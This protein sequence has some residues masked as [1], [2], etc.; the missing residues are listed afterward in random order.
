MRPVSTFLTVLLLAASC[1]LGMAQYSSPYKEF[2]GPKN[3]IINDVAL[4]GSG[5]YAAA[6]LDN[7]IAILWSVANNQVVQKLDEHE[8]S[9]RNLAFSPTS[10]LLLTASDDHLIKLWSPEQYKSLATMVGHE[11]A[12]TALAFDSEGQQFLSGGMDG[13][14]ILWKLTDNQAAVM[15]GSY[16]HPNINSPILDVAFSKDN[17]YLAAAFQNG[18]VAIWRRQSQNKPEKVFRQHRDFANAVAFVPGESLLASASDDGEIHLW[19]SKQINKGLKG[20]FKDHKDNIYDL[21]FTSDGR[22]MLSCGAGGLFL[23]TDW[24]KK[25]IVQHFFH[26]ENAYNVTSLDVH[27]DNSLVLTGASDGIARLWTLGESELIEG[28]GEISWIDP[29]KKN[30]TVTVPTFEVKACIRAKSRVGDVKL[31]WNGVPADV[32]RGLITTPGSDCT[33]LFERKIELT[34]GENQIKLS[35]VDLDKNNLVSETY[36]INY[37]SYPPADSSV[38]YLLLIGVNNYT[39]WPRLNNAI[40]DATNLRDELFAHYRFDPE[41]TVELYDS[42]ASHRRIELGLRQ[43]Q[44]RMRKHDNLLIYFSGHGHYENEYS[45]G[46]LVPYNGESGAPDQYIP[47]ATLLDWISDIDSKHTYL[48]LDACYAGRL[49]QDAL[50]NDNYNDK[51]EQIPSRRALTSGID[52]VSD[53]QPGQNSPFARALL[54]FLASRRGSDFPCSDMEQYVRTNIQQRE[55]EVDQSVSSGSLQIRDFY[56][57]EGEF[58]F[59]PK[60]NGPTGGYPSLRDR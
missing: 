20:V 51:R 18:H 56:Q 12:V 25:R 35:A 46:Y 1:G 39:D 21:G 15:L 38:N 60:K 28:N 14:L 53:G 55:G 42:M 33:Q 23:V 30:F 2:V 3:S 58:I 10:S 50:K 31:F 49:F 9:I 37:Q 34:E 48:M 26:P 13:L 27:S 16:K 40:K 11:K 57:E 52:K 7:G 44:R 29:P 5:T 24:K 59:R 41:H 19:S 54:N 45:A 32:T 22:W 36:F 6:G 47:Y 8:G 43:L 4:S 17:Q